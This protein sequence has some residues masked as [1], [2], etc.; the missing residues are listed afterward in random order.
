MKLLLTCSLL[1]LPF[2]VISQDTNAKA[3]S[4][5][6]LTPE[7]MLGQSASA[8]SD[9][10]DRKLQ[11]QLILNFGWDHK[12]NFHEWATRLKGPKTGISI[13]YTNYGNSEE[14]GSSITV[15]PFIEFNAFRKE[16]FKILTGMG[17]S[18]FNIK[19]DSISNPNNQAIT[20]NIVW[21]F[22]VFMYYQFLTSK[23]LKHRVG[24]G[25]YHHSNGHTRLPNQGLN[26]FLIS[27]SVEIK[28]SNPV[29]AKPKR[30]FNKSRYSYI[31]LRTGYSKN[32]LSKA[33][34]E[35]KGVYTISG[36]YG[37]VINKFFKLGGGFY[38]RFYQHYY[39]YI[40]D[41][42]SLVQDGEEFDFFKE[43]PWR[44]A[45]N[46]GLFVTGEFLLSHFGIEGQIGVNLHKPAYRI[47]WRINQGWSYV[48]KD[49]P[50]NA[51]LGEFDSKFN[52]KHLISTR[53]GIKY[54]FFSTLKIP[55]NN[56]Y[57]AFHINSNLG[58]ADFGEFSL[59]YVYRFNFKEIINK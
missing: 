58:Q 31:S 9:F 46:I 26:S 49:I 23:N 36:E 30:E 22:R 7:I 33:F 27:F 11:T 24:L 29:S 40:V 53:L 43:D 55:K 45:T 13:G 20:N 42:E 41:N 19:Y 34:N 57:A 15:L 1:L 35:T 44:Y 3:G 48:P 56:V 4:R 54:Y 47:D 6:V 17:L 14:I 12:N 28:K 21:S 25:Y 37:Q 38:Y 51:V 16:K 5:F 50:D 52:K 39:D 10:P 18:Y 2:S 59:G 8:N 32:V